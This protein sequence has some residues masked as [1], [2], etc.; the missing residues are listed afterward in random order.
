M[1]TWIKDVNGTK[2]YHWT[3]GDLYY[4]TD[5]S[6]NWICKNKSIE[7]VEQFINEMQV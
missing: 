2:I 1:H 3:L 7:V 5:S 6:G 4:V